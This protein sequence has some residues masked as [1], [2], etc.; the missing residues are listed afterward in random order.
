MG[1]TP[2]HQRN[3]SMPSW[4]TGG[5]TPDSKLQLRVATNVTDH[6]FEPVA[7]EEYG[8]FVGMIL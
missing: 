2:R 1:C 6:R 5:N 4:G 8:E 3:G 7:G